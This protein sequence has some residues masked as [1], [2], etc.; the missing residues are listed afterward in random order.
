MLTKEDII[1]ILI[2]YNII[3]GNRTLFCK[4]INF[5][6]DEIDKEFPTLKNKPNF[7][8]ILG[9]VALKIPDNITSAKIENKLK[10][11]E[12]KKI[13]FCYKKSKEHLYF[14]VSKTNFWEEH[15]VYPVEEKDIDK[16]EKNWKEHYI[17]IEFYK[18]WIV[19]RPKQLM[20]RF[21]LTDNLTNISFANYQKIKKYFIEVYDWEVRQ[22]L[23]N[24]FI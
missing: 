23:I 12:L 6:I 20:Y 1:K 5:R 22:E 10:K 17:P 19:Y 13:N 16:S 18:E 4:P 9:E 24:P 2:N 7:Y 15:F 14:Y 3:L 8:K 11:L 21:G